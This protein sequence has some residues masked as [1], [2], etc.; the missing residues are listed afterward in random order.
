[1]EY[2]YQF[3]FHITHRAGSKHGNADALSRQP[4]GPDSCISSYKVSLE[5]LPCGGCRYCTQRHQEWSD[6]NEHVDDVVP[7]SHTCR[8]VV[9]RSQAKEAEKP[10]DLKEATETEVTAPGQPKP[11]PEIPRSTADTFL[12][13]ASWVE[14]LTSEDLREAQLEDPELQVLHQWL[15]MRQKPPREKAASL[16][17]SLRTHWLNFE[18]VKVV[19]GVAFLQWV[20]PCQPS[21]IT[22]KLLVPAR[23]RKDILQ[24]CH[25]ST[26]AGHLGIKKTLSRIRRRFHW[27]G[28]KRDVKVHIEACPTCALSK[29][30]AKRYR[31]A[32]ADFRVGAP[33]DRLGIDILGPLPQTTQGNRCLLVIVDYF[34]RWVEVF[35]LPDQTAKIIAHSLVHDFVCS[36]GDPYR[37]GEDL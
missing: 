5:A 3:N 25:D 23:L 15:E 7:L 22:L 10:R 30:P 31:A 29:L 16:S 26:L 1:M 19:E 32:M 27:P 8:Q 12:A 2:I 28:L 14:G 33:M 6:F 13:G 37:S 34:T 4:S 21:V 9:T 24:L 36:I 20:D 11:G 17:S 18:L 35:P